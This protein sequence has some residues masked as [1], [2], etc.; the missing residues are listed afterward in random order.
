MSMST[1][2]T[3]FKP[4]DEK[5]KQMKEIYDACLKADVTIPNE[6]ERYNL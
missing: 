4:A 1:H 6:V 3:A 2:T 5:W